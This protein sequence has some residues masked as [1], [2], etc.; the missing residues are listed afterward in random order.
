MVEGPCADSV[1]KREPAR[2]IDTAV[3]D[4]LN[5]LDLNR[6]IREADMQNVGVVPIASD[7][8]AANSVPIR[9]PRRLFGQR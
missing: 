5:V 6:P 3:V 2:D 8:P 9:T 4:S 1:E 7:A